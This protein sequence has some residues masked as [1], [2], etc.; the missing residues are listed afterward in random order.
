MK[1]SLILFLILAAGQPSN[2]H[3]VFEEIGEMAG[4]LSYVHITMHLDLDDIQRQI[5]IYQSH[6]F[7]LKSSPISTFKD[8]WKGD[9][10]YYVKDV[11]AVFKATDEK[12]K[13]VIAI[14]ETAALFAMKRL[15]K[16][17]AIL[18]YQPRETRAVLG[19]IK[20]VV[21]TFMGL[22]NRVQL[23]KLQRELGNVQEQQALHLNIIRNNTAEIQRLDKE[24]D[25]LFTAMKTQSL[26]NP[27]YIT[28]AL[29]ETEKLIDH[30]L[31]VTTHVIQTL[32]QRRLAVDF[33]SEDDLKKV[34][35]RLERMAIK[36]AS[37][38]IPE[39][40]S[41]LFQLEASYFSDNSFISIILHVPLAPS[42]SV[43]R[44]FRFKPF[45][46]PLDDKMTFLPKVDTDVL[47]IS[48]GD[49]YSMEIRNGD[50]LGCHEVNK[51]YMCERHGIL[52]RK[53][54]SSCLGALYNQNFEAATRLCPMQIQPY[55]EAV[56]QLESNVY[57]IY[58]P[59][60]LTAPIKCQNGS[61]SDLHLRVGNNRH[62]LNHGCQM[63]LN[64]HVVIADSNR[65]LE[66]DVKQWEWNWDETT[67]AIL[68]DQETRADISRQL[69]E[70]IDR[71]LLS[72][73]IQTKSGRKHSVSWMLFGIAMGLILIVGVIFFICFCHNAARVKR[74]KT[75]LAAKI[76][77]V[78]DLIQRHA[79][80]WAEQPGPPLDYAPSIRRRVS[81][82]ST[83]PE[84]IYEE[85]PVSIIPPP[86][87]PHPATRQP[88]AAPRQFY[89]DLQ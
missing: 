48:H 30:S 26:A 65:H 77:Q 37:K 83:R 51:F 12:M 88:A 40:P 35:N 13:N 84:Q 56:L 38:L 57:L 81:F 68:K 85:V 2:S 33:L 62:Y 61:E 82:V 63:T 22:Y 25:L 29:V 52:R 47:A 14:H 6:L 59:T 9:Q 89:A 18:P 7:R 75:S 10:D 5:N 17:R 23:L 71:F 36:Q 78:S 31:D 86:L 1:F 11:L 27:A 8:S 19:I 73:L 20:G 21:G 24:L 72:D 39:H 66:I 42:D 64:D 32:M 87:P 80:Q 28:S 60:P 15:Q 3:V 70:G 46:I 67:S 58:T 43:L 55:Q 44:L 76:L 41:D 49:R 54:D 74:I 79:R 53:L 69:E 16:L 4:A 50:L 34:Y 45:P